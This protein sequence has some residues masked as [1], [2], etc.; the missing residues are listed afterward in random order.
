VGAHFGNGQQYRCVPSLSRKVKP[1]S[2]GRCCEARETTI[3]GGGFARPVSLIAPRPASGD[4]VFGVERSGRSSGKKCQLVPTLGIATFGIRPAIP[5]WRR[6]GLRSF[7]G[8]E[9]AVREQRGW[10]DCLTRYLPGASFPNN[11]VHL[12]SKER[13]LCGTEVS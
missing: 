5:L 3:R 11:R 6:S 9:C 8:I 4:T 2:I 10:R 12:A 7:F 13:I 1:Y